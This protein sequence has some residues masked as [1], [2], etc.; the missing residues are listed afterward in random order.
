MADARLEIDDREILRRIEALGLGSRETR[1]AFDRATRDGLTIIRTSVRKGALS[2]TS[3]L[4][5]VRIG[6]LSKN[7]KKIQ[8]GRVDILNAWYLKHGGRGRGLFRM[9][10]LEKGTR[11]GLTRYKK[12]HGA[13]PAKPFF[14]ASAQRGVNAALEETTDLMIKRIDK[15]A[16]GQA[17]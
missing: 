14:S 5:K 12:M 10:W 1:Q 3:N 11:D 13:T 8:G 9:M 2:V 16:S 7:Y 15:L 6:V 17:K 4:E